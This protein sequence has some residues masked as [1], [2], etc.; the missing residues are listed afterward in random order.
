MYSA[1]QPMDGGPV[2]EW[3]SSGTETG[4]EEPMWQLSVGSGSESSYPERLNEPDCIYYLKTGYCGYGFRCRFNHPRNRSLAIEAARAAGGEHP[5]RL[6]QAICQYYMKTGICKFGAF[7]KYH[8]PRQGVGSPSLVAHNIYGYPLRP[9][10]REC[11]HYMKTGQCK[12]GITCKFH[13]PEPAGAQG[14]ASAAGPFPFPFPVQ[15]PFPLSAAVPSPASYP[16][17]QSSSF[18]SVEQYGMVAGNWPVVRPTLLPS[19]SLPG[20]YSP[21][22]FSP[23]MVPVTGWPPYQAF[24]SPVPSQTTPPAAGASPVYGLTQLSASA[25]AYTGPCLSLSASPGASSSNQKE[26]AFPERPGQPECHHYMKFGECKYGSSCKYHHPPEWSGPREAFTPSAMGLPLRPGAPICSHYSRN[27][28][29]KFGPSCKF[30][31]PLG[32]SYSPSASSL[33]DMP[34][35]PYTAELVSGSSKEA[36]STQASCMSAATGP[37]G[38][39]FSK[40]DPVSHSTVQHLF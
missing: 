16:A 36:F 9:N 18:H 39:M 24:A 20:T 13:H 26:F 31:H 6:G 7:C 22:L 1:T 30:A 40:G 11:S 29:C 19:S 2:T 25:P 37:V 33:A 38:S 17:L 12:F 28:V 32:I 21:M 14:P 5:E 8:H 35:A 3:T 10:E 15:K 27:G 23:E 34:V 4:L